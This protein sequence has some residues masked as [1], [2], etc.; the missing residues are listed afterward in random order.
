MMGKFSRMLV[1]G[2]FLAGWAAGPVFGQAAPPTTPLLGNRPGVAA[3][4]TNGQPLTASQYF[5]QYPVYPMLGG[6]NRGVGQQNGAA[7][8]NYGYYGYNGYGYYGYAPNTIIVPLSD[9][10]DGSTVIY[11][12]GTLSNGAIVGS[13]GYYT[14]PSLSQGYQDYQPDASSGGYVPANPGQPVTNIYNTYNY[15]GSQNTAPVAPPGSAA[16]PPQG[17]GAS[18]NGQ[19]LSSAAAP[20]SGDATAGAAATAPSAQ[21]D[22]AD[23]LSAAYQ[24]IQ[25]GWLRG[26]I[27]LIKKHID[28]TGTVAVLMQSEY[29][30]TTGSDKFLSS[31]TALLNQ[32]QTKSFTFTA[33]RKQVNGDITAYA[34]QIYTIRTGDDT[35]SERTNYVSYG[36][37]KRPVG[38]VIVAVDSSQT[39]LITSKTGN[40]AN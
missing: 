19:S 23:V 11:G 25:Q 32:I 14:I 21:A 34:T 2:F 33:I 9:G 22:D 24:D 18:A 38:W 27:G 5:S 20:A 40:G 3:T 30:Y 7:Y 13:N 37:S 6:R 26:D 28:M 29:Q 36:M 12:P 8:P 4:Q 10:Y 35:T 16:P 17:Q 15:Y 39:P 1:A 31:T